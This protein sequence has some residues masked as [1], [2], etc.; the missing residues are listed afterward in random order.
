MD[1]GKILNNV[2]P[3]YAQKPALIFKEEAVSFAQLAQNVARLANA[4]R[5]LGV[6]RSV[7]VG[8]Y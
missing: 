4:L 8:I 2:S 5:S 1:I 3:K 6:E 7:K